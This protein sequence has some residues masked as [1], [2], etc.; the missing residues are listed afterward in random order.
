ME[1]C[2]LDLDVSPWSSATWIHADTEFDSAREIPVTEPRDLAI[3]G[4]IAKLLD[5]RRNLGGVRFGQHSHSF[6]PQVTV[7]LIVYGR[8]A[9]PVIDYLK[10]GLMKWFADFA[11]D[12]KCVEERKRVRQG[13]TL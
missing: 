11:G 9:K 7:G 5:Y 4:L 10:Y 1:L 2:M 6:P 12:A 8:I 13:D 3:Y